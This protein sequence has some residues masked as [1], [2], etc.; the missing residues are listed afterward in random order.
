MKKIAEII[1]NNKLGL[2]ARPAALFI[3]TAQKYQADVFIE[4][5]NEKISGKSILELLTMSISSGDK[6]KIITEG[7]DAQ[8]ALDDLLSLVNNKFGEE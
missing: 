3:R 7:T 2:H 5:N 4:K 6:F 1:L 8:L